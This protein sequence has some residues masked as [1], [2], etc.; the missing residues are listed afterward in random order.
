MFVGFHGQSMTAA[1]TSAFEDIASLG[2]RHALAKTMHTH[3]AAYF[4]LVRSLWHELS[5]LKR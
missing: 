3:T 5:S 4:W 1:Q 2:T